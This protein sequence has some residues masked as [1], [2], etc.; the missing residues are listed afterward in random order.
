MPDPSFV[1]PLIL[2]SAFV[3]FGLTLAVLVILG[4]TRLRDSAAA[5]ALTIGF[6]ASYFAVFHAQWSFVPNQA[7][8]WMPW[9]AVLGTAGALATERAC[10]ARVRLVARLAM[11]IVT[12]GVVV[13]PALASV[14]PQKAMVALMTTAVF[15]W[16]AWTYLA[17]ATASRPTP[18]FVLAIVAGG[19]ALT[20]VLDSSQSIGQLSGALASALVAFIA[21]NVPRL[22]TAFSGA[23]VGAAVLLLGALLANAY[24]YAGIS[25]GYVALLAAGLLADP[26]VEWVNGLRQRSSGA[27]SWVTAAALTA[28]PVVA[29]IGLAIKAMQEAGGY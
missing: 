29:T 17:R 20:L 11:S 12:A 13:W 7:L 27:G 9:I 22:R 10:D 8:D 6:V 21:F 2:Q 16:T 5:I 4:A 25:I 18:P 26:V 1:L 24:L 28:I 14:G 3:P 15:I 19:T 23:A